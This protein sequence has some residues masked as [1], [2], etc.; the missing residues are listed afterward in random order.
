M[1]GH[2]S[3]TDS[4]KVADGHGG[5]PFPEELQDLFLASSQVIIRCRCH[6]ILG[7]VPRIG[8]VKHRQDGLEGSRVDQALSRLIVKPQVPG[9]DTL[10]GLVREMLKPMLRDWLVQNLPQLV[11]Q[12]VAR[13]IA[14]ITGTR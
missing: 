5:E 1:L 3:R 9:S 12:I 2:G 8:E 11:E 10:E 14:R 4:E 13:E 7:L 6:L